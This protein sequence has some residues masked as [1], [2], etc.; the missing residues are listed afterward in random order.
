MCQ[1]GLARTERGVFGRRRPVA[2]PPPDPAAITATADGE[3]GIVLGAR[4][5]GERALPAA[6]RAVVLSPERLVHHLVVMGATGSGKTETALRIAW[7]TAKSSPGPV[8]FLDGKGDRQTAERFAG[9]MASAG[10]TT[11]VFPD[12]AID[13]WRGDARAIA[14]RLL[15]VVDYASDGPAAWY[16]DVAKLTIALVCEHPDGPPA[17][18]AQAL[19]RMDLDQLKAAHGP[20]SAA[21]SL[22]SEQVRQVRLRY[23]AFFAHTAGALD[24]DWSWDETTAGYLLLDSLALKDETAHLSRFLFEDFVHYFTKRKARDQPCLLVVD[25]FSALAARAGVAER[26]EQAR[27]FNTSLVLCPQHAAGMGDQDQAARILGS[28]QTIVCHRINTPEEVIALAGTRKTTE[29][30]LHYG[31]RATEPEG[32]ARLQHQFNVDP[33]H[34]RA[35]PTG[36]AYVISRGRAMKIQVTRAPDHRQTLPEPSPAPRR[37]ATPASLPATAAASPTTPVPAQLPF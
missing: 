23:H 13:G 15:E 32:S 22:T 5:S 2:A 14:N 1:A 7:A 8:F 28:V 12:E 27:A 33:N 10:R 37:V 34:V 3:H 9:L 25:E 36:A 18:S 29:Y 11:R 4:L 19:S 6:G 16:R 24:G 17:S 30:S 26:I 20:G 31:P 35:L 21:A